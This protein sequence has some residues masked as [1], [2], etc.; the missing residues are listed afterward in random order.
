[1]DHPRRGRR[2]EQALL[3]GVGVPRSNQRQTGTATVWPSPRRVPGLRLPRSCV[4]LCVSIH[5]GSDLRPRSDRRPAPCHPRVLHRRVD[6]LHGRN[7]ASPRALCRAESNFQRRTGTK[8]GLRST[9]W[10]RRASTRSSSRAHWSPR[11]GRSSDGE[12]AAP[13]VQTRRADSTPSI[14]PK[15]RIRASGTSPFTST[16]V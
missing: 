15:R 12:G 14:S 9:N 6:A 3:G 7:L 2:G 16:S 11:S 13:A 8:A 5:R 10:T 1:M 4:Q